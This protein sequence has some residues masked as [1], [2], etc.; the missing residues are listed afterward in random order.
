MKNFHILI[1]LFITIFLTAQ[2]YKLAIKNS[3]S[4]VWIKEE[5]NYSGW[6]KFEDAITFKKNKQGKLVKNGGGFNVQYWSCDCG[7]KKIDRTDGVIYNLKKEY[8]NDIPD[9]YDERI[10]PETIG[11]SILNIFCGWDDYYEDEIIRNTNIYQK[12][13]EGYEKGFL[14]GY[15]YPNAIPTKHIQ[16][17]FPYNLDEEFESD[18]KDIYEKGYLIGYENGTSANK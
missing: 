3:K 7:K 6:V 15:Y 14:S 1:A 4:S 18:S 9:S 8:S 13:L 12:F 11:E 16:V 2:D 17:N 10:I 5:G